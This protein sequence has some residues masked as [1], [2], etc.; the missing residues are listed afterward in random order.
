MDFAV[1]QRERLQGDRL[2]ALV[3]HWREALDGAPALLELPL[4]GP[5]PRVQAY[6]G[7]QVE[8]DLPPATVAALR[9]LGRRSGATLFMGLLASLAALFARYAGRPDVV[10]G[11]P[12]AGRTRSEIEPLV[13]FFVNSL[14][15]RLCWEGD[16][17]FAGLLDV[18]R[19]STLA[20][21]A[22]QE[23]PF[24][25][26]VAELAPERNLGHT[27]L[28][29]AML[30]LQESGAD[31]L[32]MPGLATET[33]PVRRGESRFDLEIG[34][35][36][37]GPT[38]PDTLRL[39][40]RYDRDLFDPATAARLAAHH[41]R[42][43]HGLL[44]DPERRLSLQPMLGPA[45]EEQLVRGWAGPALPVSAMAQETL[46]G[47]FTAQAARTP[48]APAVIFGAETVTYRELDV[49]S[50]RLAR[51]LR[52][53]GAGPEVAVGVLLERTPDLVAA[54]LGVLRSGSFYV[55]LDPA[56]PEARTAFLLEDSGARLV[57]DAAEMGKLDGEG[58][59]LDGGA[60]PDNLAYV[61]Y[62]SGST[63]R[64]K[65]VAI[66]HRSAV[67]LLRWAAEVFPAE[68]LA[69]VFAATSVCFDLSVFEI[70][71]P[72][73]RGG[74]LIL[75]DNALALAGLPAAE[76]VTLINTVPSAM[77]ELLRL[78]AVPRSVRTVNLAGEPLVPALVDRIYERTAAGRVFDLYGPSEDT[79][80]STFALR[81]PGGPATIG[82]PVA[83]TRAVL[84]DPW[85][86]PVPAGV[87]GE[88]W[89]GGAGLARGY[90][91]RPDLTAERFLPDPFAGPGER[92]YRTGDL[93]RRHADGSLELL[94]RI[95]HQVKLRGFRIE[96]GEIEAALLAHPAVRE[97]AVLALDAADAADTGVDRRLAA[98]V[99][100]SMEI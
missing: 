73:A 90:L 67:D 77:E 89:L 86:N 10:L 21:H 13:G 34:V 8:R 84:L 26:L 55:P 9:G 68:D 83:G 91:H 98:Y 70:F 36:D 27:P 43:L 11:S 87:P 2:A 82:R 76:R 15:L 100:T 54:L 31:I 80:Y 3:A 99:V 50:A 62:T 1:W 48:D 37:G 94:G 63:G 6:R 53:A 58:P 33:I 51:R 96:L 74:A 41:E 65:G 78:E 17:G 46:H 72:L 18:A 16:P 71:L 95:D 61:I 81:R 14:A 38:A 66:E 60:G 52:A 49:R 47:L 20:A 75:G 22:H 42:L 30:T 64:P 97:A 32:E 57:V 85:G 24:E 19:R 4:D 29:Q 44:E 40:W 5:R 69:G 45:E 92:L 7:A 12:V 39:L 59:E 88:V 28:F 35:I 79:T 25:K 23:L 56:Y 93:A